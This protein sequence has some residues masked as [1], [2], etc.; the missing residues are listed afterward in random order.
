LEQSNYDDSSEEYVRGVSE[1]FGTLKKVR[2]YTKGTQMREAIKL[3]L[4][5]DV[6]QIITSYL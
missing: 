1:N 2:V 3:F 4:T 5:Q 6:Q